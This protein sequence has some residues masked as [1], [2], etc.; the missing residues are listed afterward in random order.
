MSDRPR[1]TI[2]LE[3]EKHVM[4]PTRALRAALK[5][6]LRT[7]GLKC[8]SVEEKQALDGEAS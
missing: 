4:D 1:Y 6:L 7:Y 3:P 2:I 5:R 8:I